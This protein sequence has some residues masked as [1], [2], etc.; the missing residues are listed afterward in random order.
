MAVPM[1]VCQLL[2]ATWV[3]R[4]LVIAFLQVAQLWWGHGFVSDYVIKLGIESGFA[5]T[6]DG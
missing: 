2:S 1:S 5:N 4:T 3:V 6:F